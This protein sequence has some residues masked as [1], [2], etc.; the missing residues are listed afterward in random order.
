MSFPHDDNAWAETA[1]FLRSRLGPTDRLV[2]PSPFRFVIPRALRFQQLRAEPPA[3]F[4][5]VV[6][7][8]GELDAIPRGFLAQLPEQ[9][10]PVF[11]NDVFVVFATA[12]PSDLAD[13]T[14]T[15]HVRALQAG[16]A[17]L[18][19][20]VE[21]APATAGT[22][23][24]VALPTGPAADP[25]TVPVLRAPRPAFRPA[26]DA[27][28][29]PPRP[30]LAP[31]GLPGL[32]RERAFQDELDRLVVDYLGT[33]E[34]LSVLD[35]GCGGGRLGALLTGA[36]GVVGIDTDAG[37]LA[38][39]QVRHGALPAHAFARMDAARLGF[40]EASFD[41]VV[42]LDLLDGLADP[43]AALAEAARVLARGGRLMVTA[44]NKDSLPLRA[45]RRLA[46]PAPTAGVSVQELAGMLRAAGLAPMRMDGI[47]LS[48]GWAMPGTGGAMGPLEEDPEFV[49]AARL[50][51]RRCGP[52]HALAMCM[53]ARK[54]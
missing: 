20:P 27:M 33:A 14:E 17:A 50:L 43:A 45:L 54:G 25:L 6:A 24:S 31:G 11:A 32:A 12:P 30:W 36:A 39:A 49:E 52:D 34:G 38:R 26:R 19:P 37:A 13:L 2:A 46:L 18:P 53:M 1:A 8:K 9:A 23:T 48:L 16:V 15:D 29:P 3:A 10:V 40:P 5:W 44:S 21:L 42:M 47:L 28:P 51:G 7:H 35:I 41:V 22:V 4:A